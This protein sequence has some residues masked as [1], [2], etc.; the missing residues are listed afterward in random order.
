[1]GYL[2]ERSSIVKANEPV[3]SQCGW[4]HR[5]FFW[6]EEA[7]PSSLESLLVVITILK[8][9]KKTWASISK[10][11]AWLMRMIL[12]KHLTPYI[13]KQNFYLRLAFSLRYNFDPAFSTTFAGLFIHS[14]AAHAKPTV[15]DNYPYKYSKGLNLIKPLSWSF[16]IYQRQKNSRLLLRFKGISYMLFLS[17]PPPTA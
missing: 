3:L 7:Y 1:M 11:I 16:L 14:L 10:D 8:G 12:Q 5:D 13:Y 4:D 15:L 17:L 2:I 9:M 6:I